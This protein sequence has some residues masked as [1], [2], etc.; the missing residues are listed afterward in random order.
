MCSVLS[1]QGA[2]MTTQSANAAHEI[3]RPDAP[4][5]WGPDE[6]FVAAVVEVHARMKFGFDCDHLARIRV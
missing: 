5:I 1:A 2:P 4:C 6:V 3:S